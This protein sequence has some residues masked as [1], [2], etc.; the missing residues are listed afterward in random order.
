MKMSPATR[1]MVMG[2]RYTDSSAKSHYGGADENISKIRMG[3][4]KYPMNEHDRREGAESHREHYDDDDYDDRHKGGRNREKW[5]DREMIATGSAWI[6]PGRGGHGWE[7][8]PVDER[9]AMEW[10][11]GMQSPESGRPMPA[12][13]PEEAEALRKAHCPE[14]DKWEFFVAL[15]MKYS[16]LYEAAKKLNMDKPEFYAHMAKAFLCDKDAGPHKLQKYM[17]IIPK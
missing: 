8:Q 12:F 4:H 9:Q 7:Y 10:V 16:D 6:N 11:H 1:M 2:K 3:E 17:E 5:N 14:C 13:K 15:N